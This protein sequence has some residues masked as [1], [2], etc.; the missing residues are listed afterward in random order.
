M[1]FICQ[2]N[3]F[4][5]ASLDQYTKH[6][7][8]YCNS[9]LRFTINSANLILCEQ[10]CSKYEPCAGFV[11][12]E[13]SSIC[14]T[15][16]ICDNLDVIDSDATT[17]IKR[18]VDVSGKPLVTVDRAKP[19]N[20]SYYISTQLQTGSLASTLRE[21]YPI[22]EFECA[23]ACSISHDC[24]GAIYIDGQQKCKTK[25]DFSE[26]T[27]ILFANGKAIFKYNSIFEA[28]D[29]V[30]NAFTKFT[31]L[32]CRSGSV[33]S[34]TANDNWFSEVQCAELC[35]AF[36]GCIGMTWKPS[37]YGCTVW[38]YC[39]VVKILSDTSNIVRDTY[40]FRK[41]QKCLLGFSCYTF[42]PTKVLNY[43]DA[44]DECQRNSPQAKLATFETR[45]EYD[46][47]QLWQQQEAVM[48][49]P[50]WISLHFDSE[51]AVFMWGPEASALTSVEWDIPWSEGYP[52]NS[53]INSTTVINPID[54]NFINVA[55]ES[56][57]FALCESTSYFTVY[58]QA[59]EY[60]PNYN[61]LNDRSMSS[62]INENDAG[63]PTYITIE[64]PRIAY[65][66]SDPPESNRFIVYVY[67]SGLKC[68]PPNVQNSDAIKSNPNVHLYFSEKML[69]QYGANG[70]DYIR[71]G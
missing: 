14:K 3:I 67:G 70:V 54:G 23:F 42:I 32:S 64:V 45:D 9:N 16:K 57:Y 63:F 56:H 20:S 19:F 46:A 31:G 50:Y 10:V 40:V 60:A 12:Y 33:G 21:M 30:L 37:V 71:G 43:T 1:L 39:D 25:T 65:D 48:I 55:P 22:T 66:K 51:S 44:N 47:V 4:I 38:K 5:E 53:G 7:G 36:D 62:C 35:L 18:T 2:L 27:L 59:R 26:S 28:N 6:E 69:V 49:Q 41:K 8:V 11:F 17:Y 61:V 52:S 58:G 24:A 15:K 29:L 13:S 34:L 68:K